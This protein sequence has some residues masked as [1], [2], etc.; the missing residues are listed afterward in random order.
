MCLNMTS[1]SLDE[2]AER[3]MFNIE[4]AQMEIHDP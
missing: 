3:M 2:M 1:S 4:V